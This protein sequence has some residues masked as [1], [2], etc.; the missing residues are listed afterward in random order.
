MKMRKNARSAPLRR[1]EMARSVLAGETS[2]AEAAKSFGVTAK[3][4][5]KRA[6]RFQDLGPAGCADRSS[7]PRRMR[8]PTPGHVAER[9][10][11]LRR[12]RPAGARA[13][14][15]TGV[16]PATADRVLKRAGLSRIRDLEPEEPARR[17]EHDNPGDMIHLDVKKLGR[18]K[19][20]SHRA[21]GTRVGRRQGS[22]WE[23]AHTCVD[24][25][26]RVACGGLFPNERQESAVECLRASVAY[27]KRLGVTV[28]RVTADNGPCCTSK[29]FA[30][31][32]QC[33]GV[34]HVR[35]KPYTPRANGDAELHPDGHG[36]SGTAPWTGE[37]PA[38]GLLWAQ[39]R[40][41]VA[42]GWTG[43]SDRCAAP[44]ESN[45]IAGSL[46]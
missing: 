31:A 34:R 23:Y 41:S 27:Y 3:T 9:T 19:G 29:E 36:G 11:S 37:T 45:Y 18:F 10:V 24:D 4:V 17:Y 25:A 32:C 40:P 15:A 7:R 39:G 33:F 16:P 8:R 12:H 28:R 35:T 5:P 6:G 22:G 14:T 43:I 13:A 30:A 46:G 38:S 21:T 42:G 2:R 1:E 26:S 20:P 44:R